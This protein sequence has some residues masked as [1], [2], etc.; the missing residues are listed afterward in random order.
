MSKVPTA[1][2]RRPAYLTLYADLRRAIMEGDYAYG[3]K[4]P[5]TRVI[6]ARHGVSVVTVEHAL[7]I[8]LDE[9]YLAARERSGYF[10]IFRADDG[11][12]A[13]PVP[14]AVPKSHPVAHD[15]PDS[16]PFSVLARTMRRVLTEYEKEILVK[17]PNNGVL[18]LRSAICAY[19][20]RSRGIK[21]SPE[22]IVIGSGAEYLYGLVVGLLGKDRIF[23][24]EDPCYEKIPAV[25]RASGA[26]CEPLA[27]GSDGITAGALAAS[28]ATVLHI[29]PYRSF[30]SGITASASKRQE[31]LAFAERRN[32]YLVEDDFDSEFTV[33]AK[34]EDTLF[35]LDAE[36]VI[37]INT[38]SRTV[39]PAMRMGY[40]I[41]PSVLL[42]CF[43]ERVG[44]YSCT[45]PTFE[46]YVLAELLDSGDFERHINRVRRAG[47][48]AAEEK[49]QKR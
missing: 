42:P 39:A 26:R 3:T 17:S 15:I 41:L 30:P 10:A 21:A 5:S 46:Q 37:Y 35:S 18:A 28:A 49:K 25:Y 29:T 32:G 33:S 8:L 1:K 7:S 34:T 27:M 36:R 16:F 24:V 9:G 19:L 4:L 23:G 2:R 38:F 20:S 31:Y 14:H 11:F 45:V 48:R 43:R 47:R 6:A 22:Q 13:P 12:A 40:M 44:F